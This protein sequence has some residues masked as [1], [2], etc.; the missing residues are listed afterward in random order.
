VPD[1]PGEGDKFAA[2]LYELYEVA[3][4][5]L[6]PLADLY[7][8]LSRQLEKSSDYELNP[9]PVAGVVSRGQGIFRSGPGL[10]ALRDDV[11]YAFARS[12]EN[13]E[14]AAAT[15]I[16]V[17]ENYAAADEDTQADF[18][19][20]QAEDFPAGKDRG[21]SSAPVYPDGHGRHSAPLPKD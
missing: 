18:E 9:R 19:A 15:L 3:Q 11:Q 20:Q 21:P 10:L 12:S 14:T 13:I 7:G 5:D 17:A 1:S 16:E 4:K 2:D 6:R 8:G